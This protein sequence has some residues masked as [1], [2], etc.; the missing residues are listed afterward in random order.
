M[1]SNSY[2]LR[3]ARF[4]PRPKS[5][6]EPLP[7]A[8]KQKSVCSDSIPGNGI[9]RTQNVYSGNEIMGCITMHK[10]NTIPIRRDNKQE[11]LEVTRM[12]HG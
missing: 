11:I 3:F 8:V 1:D 10:S 9:K 5:A 7:K 4:L 2:Y 12:R 6:P